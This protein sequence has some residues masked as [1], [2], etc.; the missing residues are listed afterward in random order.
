[1][2]VPLFFPGVNVDLNLVRLIFEVEVTG[3]KEF[4]AAIAAGFRRFDKLF[5]ESCCY[6]K[7]IDCNSCSERPLCPFQIVFAQELSTNPDIVRRHQK[8]PLPF[9]FKI[10][11]VPENK[12]LMEVS[13]VVIGK[14]INHLPVFVSAVE[15]L[16]DSCS[17][18][19]SGNAPLINCI[20]CLDY[21]SV[22]HEINWS[23]QGDLNLVVLSSLEIMKNSLD[24]NE[25]RLI[26][27]SPLKVPST[28]S[29]LHDFEFGIF[30]RSQMRRC[31][32]LF[33]YY[34]DGE[35]DIDFAELSA[36]VGVVR[37]H[38]DGICYSQPYWSQRSSHA[39]LLGIS[40]FSNLA[41]GML[42]LLTLG[43][44]FNAG[45]GASFGF[46][47]YNVDAV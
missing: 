15:L 13:L 40:E 17:G 35:L 46:G 27:E 22:R 19:C 29:L 36:A 16:L 32:S 24:T 34:G 43:S 1:M 2:V 21:Q 38:K 18:Q 37:C 5:K 4:A 7:M 14:A 26:L 20:H 23:R 41:P 33:A 47:A 9:A 39:G 30:L 3:K 44:Y 12:S 8:P 42:P 6:R 11:S 45:K 28:G 10:S 31:S 25:A